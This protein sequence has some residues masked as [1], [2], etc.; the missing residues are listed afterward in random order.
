MIMRVIT[1]QIRLQLTIDI[2]RCDGDKNFRT[3]ATLDPLYY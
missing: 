1:I 2:I 3:Q